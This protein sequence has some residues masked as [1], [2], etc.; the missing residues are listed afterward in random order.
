MNIVLTAVRAWFLG[1]VILGT[2]SWAAEPRV[3]PEV[4]KL[5]LQIA[6]EPIQVTAHLYKPKGDG[7]FPLVIFSHGRASTQVERAKLSHPILVGHANYWLRQGV[8]VV[9][10]VRPGY[11]DTGG[12]DRENSFARWDGG[13]CNSDPDFTKI[14]GQA[15]ETI[16]ATYQWAQQQPWVR[17]DRILLEGQSAGGLATVAAGALN[18]PGVVGLVN[19]AGGV[20]GNPERSPGKSCK[21]ENLTKTYAG[22]GSQVKVPSLWLYADN[23]Q[24]WGPEAP[25]QWHAAFEAGGSATRFVQTGALEGHDGH[26]L[27]TQGGRMWSVPLNAF[28]Q[29]L[30]FVSK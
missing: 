29:Q 9:A 12:L 13:T 19:F 5:A 21:P 27:L 14:A 25:R 7:P 18:L 16:T 30:G 4:V 22:F 17:K 10:P 6:G 15:R 1:C 3:E 2:S 24:Y 8:A 11:G 23:D 20:G 26:R 28:V